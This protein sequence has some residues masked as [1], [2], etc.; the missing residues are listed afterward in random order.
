METRGTIYIVRKGGRQVSFEGDLQCCKELAEMAAA[1]KEN[2]L[3]RF[4]NPNFVTSFSSVDGVCT[5][6]KD[7]TIPIEHW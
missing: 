2:A 6:H 1:K 7:V 4:F 5:E 3:Y